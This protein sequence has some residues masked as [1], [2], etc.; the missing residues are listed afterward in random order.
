MKRN[1]LCSVSLL[2]LLASAGM[3]ATVTDAQQMDAAKRPM[4]GLDMSRSLTCEDATV[5]DCDFGP[6]TY[7]IPAGGGEWFYYVGTGLGLTMETRFATT[8]IDSDLYIYT[9][10]CGA[11]TQAFYRDGDSTQGWKTYLNCTDFN[12][13]AGQGYYIYVTD[14]SSGTGDVTIDFT[15]CEFTPFACPPNSLPY[16]E[17]NEFGCGDYAH[18]I[19]CGQVYCGEIADNDDHDY[20]WFT[21]TAPMTTMTLNVYGN[22]TNGRAPFGYG[23]DPYIRVYNEDCT[24]LIAED[25]DSGTG[26]DSQLLLSCMTPGFYIVEVNT[27][28]S[29]PGPYLLTLD[30]AVC[31]W[32]T[33]AVTTPDV[34]IDETNFSSFV[35][36]A[37]AF[38]TAVSLCD[39][40]SMIAAGPGCFSNGHCIL[41]LDGGEYWFNV[42]QPLTGCYAMQMR[43][44]PAYTDTCTPL[45]GVAQNGALLGYFALDAS[46][47]LYPSNYNNA[48]TDQTTFVIDAPAACCDLVHVS[49]WYE[50]L[51]PPVEAGDQPVSFALSQNVPNPFNPATTISFTLPESG[52]ASLKVYDTAGREVATLVNGLSAR[53]DHQVTFDGSQLSTGVYFYTLQFNGQS[54]TQKMVLVK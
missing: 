50:D 30:C 38:T 11:L 27:E 52:F 49:I 29:A 51:C 47:G 20:F 46:T 3:A 48:G 44:T 2:G 41:D 10:T 42:Y 4:P 23:L 40:C 43:V 21:V 35:G 36:E 22:D 7:T 39:Y 53:G 31:C 17:A 28:W 25:D 33:N 26:Y 1:L 14:Y 8:T 16:N 6:N 54:Q 13:V 9:G 18:S 34:V 24:V 32:E 15:C 5:I 19:D 12:F 45:V 37:N